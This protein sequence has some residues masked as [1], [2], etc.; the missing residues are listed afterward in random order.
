MTLVTSVR[1]STIVFGAGLL[2]QPLFAQQGGQ[3][4]SPSP[5]PSSGNTGGGNAG[6]NIPGGNTTTPGAGRPS[7]QLPGQ[8]PTQQNRMDF[9]EM[10]RPIFLSGKVR[11]D[12]GTPPPDTVVI[13]RVC[14]GQG[15]PEAYT[16]SKGHFSFELG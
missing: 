5:P 1:V 12:D 13:E 3:G 8:N 7:T 9:P 16:D 4:A 10:N 6:G 2:L 14:G 15:R 11:L